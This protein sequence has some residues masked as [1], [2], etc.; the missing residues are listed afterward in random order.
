MQL[1]R[2]I[3]QRKSDSCI[4]HLHVQSVQASILLDIPV[5]SMSFFRCMPCHPK[6]Q[7]IQGFYLAAAAGLFIFLRGCWRAADGCD[8]NGHGKGQEG[9]IQP[10]SFFATRNLRNTIGYLA[11]ARTHTQSHN[12]WLHHSS[13]NTSS[14]DAPNPLPS[15]GVSHPEAS[16]H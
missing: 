12:A 8:C 6:S 14:E 7:L 11:S 3:L 2:L 10:A 1:Q 9:G 4:L 16:S 13:R 5:H 15:S